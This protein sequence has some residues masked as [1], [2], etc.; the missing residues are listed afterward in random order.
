MESATE[1]KLIA[2]ALKRLELLQKQD[3]FDPVYPGSRPTV[4]QQEVFNDFGIIKQQWIRAGNQ[5]GKSATCA[6]IVS[7]VVT[8]THP[9]WK[10]P[11][12]WSNEPLLILVAA[13]TGK[14]IED[15]LL[16]KIRGFLEHGTYK[17]VRVGNIVQRVEFTN[18]NR[19]V[20]QSLENHNQARE[21]LQ[22]YTAHLVWIDEL[23]PTLDIVRELLIRV[24]ARN[25]YFLA[26]FTPTVVALDIQRFVDTLR[27]P[28]GKVYRFNML[29]NPLYSDPERRAELIAR[30]AHL[31]EDIREMVFKGEWLS[32]DDQV[33]YFNYASMVEMPEGYSP[34][35][36]HVE[37]ADPAISSALGLTIWA[38]NPDSAIWYCI[39]A[40]YVKGILVP[41]DIVR[42][43]Q[44]YTRNLNVVKR[45]SDYA[46]WFT[47]TAHAMGIKYQ[48]VD[49]KNH[50]RKPELIKN[51]QQKLGSKIRIAPH[52]EKLIR[53]LQE[54]RWS[55]KGEGRIINHSSFHLLDSAQYFVDV[56]PKSEE[57]VRYASMEDYIYQ[58]HEK[59][60]MVKAKAEYRLLKIKQNK[61]R[62]SAWR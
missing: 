47:N 40:E 4:S 23:P 16:P 42:E 24:Q 43:V 18:G 54:C 20:F 14:H 56:M 8:D 3:A 37:A 2:T 55:D 33:Y 39:R 11:E 51:L 6:R 15:S 36:R 34:L 53:E 61:G 25:G 60:K 38:E 10:K 28:E 44:Q 48:T 58:A 9:T 29:D 59:R 5:S 12:G 35:W 30:Y 31:P 41:T 62:K 26:S 13:K 27:E 17:E 46:P 21:R 32:G 19:I 7:W 45:I 1:Q 22:S 52:C 57:K 49:S 50:G